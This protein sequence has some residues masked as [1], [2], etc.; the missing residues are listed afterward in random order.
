AYVFQRYALSYLLKKFDTIHEYIFILS[1]GWC[2][3]MGER[4]N[5]M[6]LSDEIGAFIAG[7]ALASNPISMY[8][9]ESLKPLR[10]FFLVIFFFTVGATFNFG[11]AAEV[12]IPAC[13]L[14]LLM[15]IF[16]PLLFKYLLIKS[17]EKKAIAEE[18]GF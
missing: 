3:L 18:V 13:L 15:L 12:V 17:G 5:V 14:A 6:G 1:I 4:A 7:V 11:Y 2:L 10:D 8:I 16:K 9:A